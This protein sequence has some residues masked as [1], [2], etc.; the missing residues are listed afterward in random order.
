MLHIAVDVE[1]AIDTPTNLIAEVYA[2]LD[3]LVREIDEDDDIE[4]DEEEDED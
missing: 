4:D 2:A 1:P 3:A